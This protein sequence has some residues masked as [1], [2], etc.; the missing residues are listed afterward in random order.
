MSQPWRLRQGMKRGGSQA[1]RRLLIV[2]HR[3]VNRRPT[4]C[5]TSCALPTPQ[6]EINRRGFSQAI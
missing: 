1:N 3:E 6:A 2:S 5:Q 4:P